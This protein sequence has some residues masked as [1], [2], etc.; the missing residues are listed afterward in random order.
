MR[1]REFTQDSALEAELQRE[2]SLAAMREEA[3]QETVNAVQQELD[4][5]REKEKRV[6]TDQR[7]RSEVARQLCQEKDREIGRLLEVIASQGGNPSAGNSG[8]T[9]L[10]IVLHIRAYILTQY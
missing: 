5:L 6:A 10:L 7:K 1:D 8:A 4:E 3:L 2:R 9:W